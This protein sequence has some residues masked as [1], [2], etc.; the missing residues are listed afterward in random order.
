MEGGWNRYNGSLLS[1]LTLAYVFGEFAH[2]LIGV[3]RISKY[4]WSTQMIQNDK[5]EP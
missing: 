2:Y 5:F 4:F 1:L 3:V